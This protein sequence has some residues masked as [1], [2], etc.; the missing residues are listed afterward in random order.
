VVS[1]AR[2][3]CFWWRFA[4]QPRRV[5][6]RDRLSAQRPDRGRGEW[7]VS[8]RAAAQPARSRDRLRGRERTNVAF[9]GE[10]NPKRIS[11]WRP[12]CSFSLRGHRLLV[13]ART[14]I[15][16][17]RHPL[18]S[19]LLFGRSDSRHR[20]QA[21]ASRN[22]KRDLAARGLLHAG[23]RICARSRRPL[24][25]GDVSLL[26]NHSWDRSEEIRRPVAFSSRRRVRVSESAFVSQR[27][28]EV[29][30]VAQRERPQCA[31]IPT[32]VDGEGPPMRS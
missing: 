8:L 23:G 4:T 11:H 6:S 32:R 30:V 18:L 5:P 21:L 20:E 27:N 25:S 2:S 3:N 24:V 7:P 17:D 31:V 10:P 28:A 1:G 19:R 26:S 13:A 15:R 22:A 29:G 9:G 16:P 12:S 14:S